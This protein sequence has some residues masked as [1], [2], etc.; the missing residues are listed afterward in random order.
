MLLL[1]FYSALEITDDGLLPL[2]KALQ[3]LSYLEKVYLG[4]LQ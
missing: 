2:G 4:I 3:S 1:T